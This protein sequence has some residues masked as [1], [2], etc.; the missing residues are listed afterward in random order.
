M[1]IRLPR[2]QY[3]GMTGCFS[4]Y[5]KNYADVCAPLNK[6]K[7]KNAIFSWSPECQLLLKN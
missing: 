4:K 6:L 3:I 5:I 2:I 7:K 1:Y